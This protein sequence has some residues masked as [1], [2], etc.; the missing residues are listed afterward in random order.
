MNP[1]LRASVLLSKDMST[2]S[3]H[4]IL[5]RYFDL[6]EEVSDKGNDLLGQACQLFN[7][8]DTGGPLNPACVPT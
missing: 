1:V 4:A 5:D 2:T 8:K 7:T 6:L 3:D